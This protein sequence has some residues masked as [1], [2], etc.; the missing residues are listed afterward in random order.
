MRLLDWNQ[1]P[2]FEPLERGEAFPQFHE[3][4]DRFTWRNDWSWHWPFWYFLQSE[5]RFHPGS[6]DNDE[7]A[8]LFMGGEL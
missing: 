2:D 5:C 6:T 4:G 3:N 8:M 7:A 1:K